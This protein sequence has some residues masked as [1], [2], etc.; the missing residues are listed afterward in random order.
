MWI[1]RRPRDTDCRDET[2][3]LRAIGPVVPFDD[4]RAQLAGGA[5]R[6][7]AEKSCGWPI[8][9][10]RSISSRLTV[11]VTSGAAKRAGQRPRHDQRAGIVA[12][13]GVEQ[14]PL[15][16]KQP[17]IGRGNPVAAM[18]AG[19]EEGVDRRGRSPAQ[20]GQLAKHLSR[21]LA[22]FVAERGE[23]GVA[24]VESAPLLHFE[25]VALVADEVDR[26]A[27]RQVAA[28]RRIE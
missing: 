9:R 18:F 23:I 20:L 24:V 5:P 2:L 22:P 12:A 25:A 7:A 8:E 4:R 26:H 10:L 1:T 3:D 6:V 21:A 28:H 15:P 16:A 11:E 17:P 27:H 13:V 14:R 19:D